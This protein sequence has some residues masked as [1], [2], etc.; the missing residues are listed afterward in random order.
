MVARK[1]IVT[2]KPVALTWEELE[3]WHFDFVNERKP[4][5]MDENQQKQ[6]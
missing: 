6:E 4:K 3:F 5:N 1:R 2:Y